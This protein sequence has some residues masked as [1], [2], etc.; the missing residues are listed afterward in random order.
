MYFLQ[1]IINKISEQSV[2]WSYYTKIRECLGVFSDSAGEIGM[3]VR[4]GRDQ[5][6]RFD[7]DRGKIVIDSVT[8]K[9][10][11]EDA[12]LAR[13]RDNFPPGDRGATHP[14]PERATMAQTTDRYDPV[15]QAF[16]WVMAIV[17]VLAYGFGLVREDMPKGDF[18]NG[19][20]TLHMSAGLLVFGLTM[21]RLTWRAGHPAPAMLVEAPLMMLAAKA[22]HIALYAAMIAI[23]L[24]GLV[25][26]WT[27]GKIVSFFW[28]APLPSPIALDKPFSE[29][30]EEIHSVAAHVLM[31]VAGLHALAAIAHHMILKDATL[32]RMLPAGLRG[33]L[34]SPSA[35]TGR[36]R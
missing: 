5:F 1:K 24:A 10:K 21:L 9:I 26:A 6:F 11:S 35:D 2:Y 4:K 32:L 27:N 12:I 22:A 34:A 19:L 13:L 3:D 30:L 7:N 17:V 15:S 16:H 29:A 20:L 14:E 31:V 33:P 28:V 23:P 25:S 8:L 18:R 36:N